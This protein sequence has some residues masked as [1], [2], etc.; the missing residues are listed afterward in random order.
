MKI[1]VSSYSFARYLD[2]GSM[3]L[4]AAIDKAAELGFDGIEFAGIGVDADET[5]AKPLA[6]KIK[7]ACEKAGLPI[8]SYTIP[9]DFIGKK[10]GWQGEVERLKGEVKIA[11]KLGVPLMRHD[12]C[13]AP[14]PG[15]GL[16]PES[17]EA[18]Q[19]VLPEL[20]AGCRAVTEFA[21]EMGVKTTVENHGLFVQDSARCEAL[22]KGVDHPNFGALVDIGNF[23]C[24]DEEPLAAVTRMAPH[25]SYC[26]VKDFH[27]K[28]SDGPDPGEGW[29][30]TRGGNYLRGAIIGHGDIDIPACLAAIKAAGYQGPVSIEFEGMEENFQALKI[31]LENLR[32]YAE[33]VGY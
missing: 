19:M 24:A 27:T 6:G 13:L 14:Q 21:S 3:D 26:H 11:A 25:A 33:A 32:R 5:T 1:G 9:A 28:P 10:I 18:F 8:F 31:G 12:A 4:F 22:A 16:G 23:L 17:D 15:C 29:F 2:D 7:S 30:K 20:I